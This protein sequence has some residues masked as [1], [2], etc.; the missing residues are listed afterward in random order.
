M[1]PPPSIENRAKDEIEFVADKCQMLVGL[2]MD[3]DDER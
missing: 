2:A 1:S 3:Y